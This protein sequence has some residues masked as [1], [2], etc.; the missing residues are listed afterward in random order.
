[1]VPFAYVSLSSV[2]SPTGLEDRWYG[3]QPRP[4]PTIGCRDN[5][6][7]GS[8]TDRNIGRDTAENDSDADALYRALH[9]GTL[10]PPAVSCCVETTGNGS[11]QFANM[12]K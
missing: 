4:V 1:M 9:I 5:G 3:Y 7:T 6:E 10:K 11:Q 12:L 8:G 2:D